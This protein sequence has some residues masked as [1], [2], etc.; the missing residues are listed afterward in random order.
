MVLFFA[1]YVIFSIISFV[2]RVLA[3]AASAGDGASRDRGR[4]N[5]SARGGAKRRDDGVIELDKDQYRVE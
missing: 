3:H 2:L 1:G 5:E 4:T